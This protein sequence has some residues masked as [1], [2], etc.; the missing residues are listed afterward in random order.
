MSSV[1]DILS[2]VRAGELSVKKAE[3]LLKLDAVAV[4]GDFARLD[5]TRFLRRGVPE[6][7]YAQNKSVLQIISIV[8]KLVKTK[9]GRSS[10][11]VPIILSRVRPDQ[12]K[13]ILKNI[14]GYDR[15]NGRLR[16][17]YF[18]EANI[19][20]IVSRDYKLVK[21]R[22]GRVALIPAGTSDLPALNEAEVV[23]NLLGFT[24]L[25]FNDVGVA[26]LH[27]LLQPLQRIVKF[28]PDAIIV[29]AGMEGALPTVV[30]GLS[31]VPV[32]GLPTSVGYGYG[33]GG[34]AALMSMLQACSLGV[35]VVNI[36]AGVAAGVVASLISRRAHS[37]E[38]SLRQSRPSRK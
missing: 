23:L 13:E 22:R 27:R 9:I 37:H 38:K 6:I 24:T 33:K 2:A 19:I 28:D 36:D 10:T 30:A 25:R 15:L 16:I 26:G 8:K 4:V 32:I 3:R 34:E 18:P 11:D 14:A 5:F 31:S 35:S 29:A 21:K 12:S 7:V 1:A 17:R 20:A